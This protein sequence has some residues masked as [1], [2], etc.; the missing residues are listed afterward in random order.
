MYDSRFLEKGD[1]NETELYNLLLSEEMMR[2]IEKNNYYDQCKSFILCGSMDLNPQS[3]AYRFLL[4]KGFS[5][6]GVNGNAQK[7]L[8]TWPTPFVPNKKH[9]FMLNRRTVDFIFIKV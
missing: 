6:C 7:K 8:F 4:S 5:N 3:A 9:A 2:F 1:L